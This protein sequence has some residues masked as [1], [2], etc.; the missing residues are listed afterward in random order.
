MATLIVR[1][2]QEGGIQT[3]LRN[4]LGYWT[5]RDRY[6]NGSEDVVQWGRVFGPMAESLATHYYPNVRNE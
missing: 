1:V 2:N 6:G 4:H 3:V 5:V